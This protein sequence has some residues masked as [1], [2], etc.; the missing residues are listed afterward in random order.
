MMQA[1]REWLRGAME[2][3]VNPKALAWYEE[4]AAEIKVGVDDS[5]FANLI[6]MASRH[7]RRRKAEIDEVEV[8]R[9][10]EL[11]PGWNPENWSLLDLLRVGL[12]LSRPDLE[13]AGAAPSICGMAKYAD[14]GELCALYRSLPLLP[15]PADYVWQ[16]GEGCRSN[17]NEVFQAIACDN[18]FPVSHFD[19]VAWRALV[20]KAIFIDAPLWRVHGIDQRHSDDLAHVALDLADERRSAGRA[21]QPQLWL[22]LGARG[23]ERAIASLEHEMSAPEPQGRQGAVLG[24]ARAGQLDQLAALRSKEH[25][26]AVVQ[27]IDRALAGQ[28]S[29][30]EY[31]T[32]HPDQ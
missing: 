18:P 28:F 20:V 31:R 1:R 26:A 6:S 24:L 23:G 19:D 21:V 27:T 8:A 4:A 16:A 11:L 13:E 12:I 9:A 22:S 14:V 32:L 25:D 29:Q 15:R 17:M 2:S 30:D 10:R 7:A 5:R 3:R